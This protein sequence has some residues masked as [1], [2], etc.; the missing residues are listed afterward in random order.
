MFLQKLFQNPFRNT[1]I[2][3]TVYLYLKNLFAFVDL[4]MKSI[5]IFLNMIR[6]FDGLNA[7]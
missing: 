6:I 4:G 7:F 3:R 1:F 5:E 2:D